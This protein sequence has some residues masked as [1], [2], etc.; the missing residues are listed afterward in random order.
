MEP[1]TELRA[2]IA[3]KVFNSIGVESDSILAKA[4]SVGVGLSFAPACYNYSCN[5]LRIGTHPK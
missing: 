2:V 5:G 3:V 4:D 1:P